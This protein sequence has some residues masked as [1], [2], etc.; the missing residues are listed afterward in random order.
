MY[1]KGSIAS[2]PV[3]EM[4]SHASKNLHGGR[5]FWLRLAPD[6]F[7]PNFC[8]QIV[9]QKPGE[10]RTVIVDFAADFPVKELAGKQASYAVTVR[11]IK[12]KVLAPMDDDLAAK[13]M[14]GKTLTDL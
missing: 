11:E 14:P 12:Q 3:S 4:A 1:F 9:G 8:E 7:L 5:K 10:S 2:N 6:N 13:L